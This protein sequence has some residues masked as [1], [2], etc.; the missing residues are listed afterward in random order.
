VIEAACCGAS[1]EIELAEEQ[2]LE[3]VERERDEGGGGDTDERGAGAKL[4]VDADRDDADDDKD[5]DWGGE[6]DCSSI[7]PC[8]FIMSS[9]TILAVADTGT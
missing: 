5:E 9:A 4:P 1:S 2:L 8:L 3:D 6:G 7:P